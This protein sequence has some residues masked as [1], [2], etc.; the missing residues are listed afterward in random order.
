MSE[1]LRALQERVRAEL[2]PLGGDDAWLLGDVEAFEAKV[3]AA[4]AQ[5]AAGNATLARR[6]DDELLGWG[7]LASV[8]GDLSVQELSVNARDSIWIVRDG[9][10]EAVDL[11][12]PPGRLRVL[13]ESQL[14]RA[15][16]Q[17]T[18]RQPLVDGTLRD[19]SRITAR[20]PAV[21]GSGEGSFTLRRQSAAALTLDDLVARGAMDA[22]ICSLLRRAVEEGRTVLV[23]G[24]LGTG[25]TTLLGALL[26][27]VP[28]WR[29]VEI[30]EDV[31]E[32]PRPPGRNVSDAV[33]RGAGAEGAGGVG[34]AEL[35]RSAL[36]N[37]A[38]T[39]VL[40]EVRGSEAAVLLDAMRTF[41]GGCMGSVHGDDPGATLA[42]FADLAVR[43]GADAGRVP[44]EVAGAV[45]LVVYL[46]RVVDP[47]DGRA[48]RRV[49]EVARPRLDG[50]RLVA[51]P[52]VRWADGAWEVHDLEPF[53]RWG[54]TLGRGG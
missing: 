32:L 8:W 37:G 35:L 18:Y 51:S 13:L 29:R 6:L 26:L 24:S 50:G 42:R 54:A 20:A 11:T 9:S 22:G 3:R 2:D 4:I 44:G 46:S 27:A 34:H 40:G 43:G 12:L 19:G 10:R 31:V 14:S 53:H 5:V 21:T 33:T 52:V 30:I 48:H 47:T 49:T 23:G 39:V 15:G 28:R 1:E 17:L 25:K 45:D 41:E 36:R 38:D 7:P 16:L